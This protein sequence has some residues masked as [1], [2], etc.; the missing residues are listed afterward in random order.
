MRE[1]GLGSLVLLVCMAVWAHGDEPRVD[2]DRDVR[3]ILS[4]NC[5]ACHGP[6]EAQR[7]TDY[8]LDIKADALAELEDGSFAIVPGTSAKSALLKRITSSDSDDRMPPADSDKRL[9]AKQ[10]ETLRRWIDQGAQWKEHWSFVA[11][12]RPALPT[13]KDQARV[14]DEIDQ[15]ILARLETEGLTL[16]PEA[17]K[18]TLLR[19]VTYD[20]TG[21]PPTID[22]IDAFLDDDSAGA[23]ERVVDRLLHSS[24]YGEHLG[25]HWLDAARYGD[26]HGLHLD[27][28]RSIWL[29]RDWVIDAFNDNMPFDRFT[30]EQLAGD[31]L[32]AP[33][34]DQLIATG[35]SRC[36]VTTSE[37][38]SIK[39]E[40]L[41][42]YAV[43]RVETTATV[44]MG[45]T[46]GCAV[47]HDH[48]YDPLS[49]TD[50]YQLFAYFN[51]LT[52]KAMDG[53]ALLPPPVLAV[54][55]LEQETLQARYRRRAGHLRKA[56]EAEVAGAD[57]IDPLSPADFASD[58]AAKSKAPNKAGFGSQLAWEK[59]QLSVDKPTAPKP[60]LDLIKV[61]PTKRDASQQKQLRN[62]F[63]EHVCA[64]TR[65]FFD[66]LH[67]QVGELEKRVAEIEKSIPKTLIM[68]DMPKPRDAYVLVRG[69][70][71]KPDK[72][73][74]VT[75]GVPA[76]LPPLP[77]DAAPNRLALAR[78][79]VDRAHP[80]TA[81]VIVNRY[82][83]RCFG[84]GIVRTAED[85]GVQG[86]LPTHPR[87]LDWLAV[88]FIESGWDIKRMQKLLVMSAT[89]R[90]SS[91]V[92]DE[93]Y[94][95]DPDNRLLARGP[96]FRL[97]AE[98]IRDGALAVGGLL[99]P[100]I[101][102]P[103]VKP[104]QPLGLWH[105]V[106]YTDSNTANFKQDHG[107]ALYRRG[108]YTFWKR[109]SP[110]PTMA[111][112]DAPSR[113]SCTVRRARTNTPLQALVLM[114]DTQYVEAARH[115]AQRMMTGAGSTPEDR[116]VFGF[117]MVTAR[118]PTID[119]RGVLL[120]AYAAHLAEYRNDPQAALELISVGDSERDQT[121]DAS[122][123]AAWTMIANLL[124]NLDETITKG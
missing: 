56:I 1:R 8:R 26:T 109:T 107:D 89:Y 23:Y 96:R 84:T 82:W 80:L 68:R 87:L 11:P 51:S 118:H 29:Y 65:D 112:F 44:W 95:A 36:N 104:Y 31:L 60:I 119:E 100:R 81:R 70:Y 6:D 25:R 103:S 108:M 102:G 50:F 83:Q 42:R 33:T 17:E 64:E 47:C 59:S 79:L 49:Q 106:G 3:P 97:D 55:T 16:A 19:R 15:F 18:T 48:K 14:V 34:R 5:Y 73:R 41:V 2:Y 13:V 76:A 78:W 10:I 111:M 85:F 30:I 90:Q 9:T 45:L 43:D 105:A 69:E 53:N 21:L 63:V 86:D 93:A 74:K 88:E 122:E 38:G 57:Y 101:G 114:N 39:E 61:D 27:N 117:R 121:L 54:P 67:R 52:E 75:P 62:Y 32:T 58:E 7:Q 72:N 120:D 66:P 77:K 4:N 28:E 35:F 113:E 123:L 92:T 71:D 22:E 40:Y 124:L 20:L 46:A 116:I 12:T 37:G 110:P 91:R 94:A 99:V 24:R 98:A 115:L